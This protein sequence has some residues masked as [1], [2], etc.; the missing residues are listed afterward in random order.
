MKLV[1]VCTARNDVSAPRVRLCELCNYKYEPNHFG[2]AICKTE[3]LRWNNHD[4]LLSA[5]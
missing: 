3:S 2:E 5:P 4:W 1:A